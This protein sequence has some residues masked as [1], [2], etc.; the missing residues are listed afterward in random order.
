[1]PH[2]GLSPADIPPEIIAVCQRLR[3]AGFVAYLVGGAVRDHLRLPPGQAHA[4][5][6]DI[7]T[8][9]PPEEV[10][11]V[12]G[13]RHTVPTGIQH[14][15]VTVLTPMRGRAPGAAHAA[16]LHREHVE[17]TT[18]RGE[19]AYS[20]GRRPDRVEFHDDLTEDL[21]RRDFTINAIA[22]DPVS[23]QLVDPF[24]GQGDLQRRVLRA[25]GDARARFGEDG[26]RIMRAVRFAAQLGFAVDPATA[27][28]IP[29]ALAT[30]R[31][32]S[33][34]RTRDELLKLL[35]AP[36]PTVGLRL[37][38]TTGLLDEVLP[39]LL[40]PHG[41]ERDAVLWGT[42][43][44]LPADGPG[45]PILRLLALLAPAGSGAEPALWRLKLSVRERE[46][47]LAALRAGP[48]DFE[49]GERLEG[50]ALRRFLSQTTEEL[51]QDLLALREAQAAERGDAAAQAG[52]ADLRARCAAELQRR[53]PL[54]AA[55][56]A[57]TG[58]DV[59]DG[60]GVPPGKVVGQILAAALDLV[61]EEPARNTREELL[62]LLPELRARV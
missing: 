21:R 50:G 29:E 47:L 57:L 5:D 28:A 46:R 20:D 26:L 30:F 38:R 53:P 8:S 61:L 45:G 25:V 15:T 11:R 24:D 58:K 49:V 51:R 33:A 23:D 52:V 36:H 35:K 6:F 34:E 42:I 56:L 12:F 48:L 2:P 37:M 16:E 18:F 44:R 10:I 13:K 4:K 32:V 59:M 39:E 27:A 14:G 7:A 60:L 9:A 19:S 1:M 62:A 22:Y 43:E 31:K 41:H 40:A 55:D 54:R 17:V 3:D